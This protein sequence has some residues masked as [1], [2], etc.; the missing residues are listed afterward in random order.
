MPQSHSNV[1]VHLVFS[2]KNREPFIATDVR[3]RLHNRRQVPLVSFERADKVLFLD[4][5]HIF[6]A[7]MILDVGT[8]IQ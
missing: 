5:H 6:F 4:A 7:I 8:I 2:T 3:P 1:L